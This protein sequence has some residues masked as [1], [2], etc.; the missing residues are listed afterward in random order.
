MIDGLL[1]LQVEK[2]IFLAMGPSLEKSAMIPS[3][4]KSSTYGLNFPEISEWEFI[5]IWVVMD[6][7]ENLMKTTG[8]LPGKVPVYTFTYL[9]MQ[10]Q[11]GF[12]FMVLLKA[13]FSRAW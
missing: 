6:P 2:E 11:E 4:M 7:Y 10:F 3:I 8:I 12:M 1:R 13:V 9:C 5:I